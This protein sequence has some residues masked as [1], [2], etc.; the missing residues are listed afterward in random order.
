MFSHRTALEGLVHKTR[1]REIYWSLSY[2]S[3]TENATERTLQYKCF[4]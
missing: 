1:N 2:D 3:G 4:D